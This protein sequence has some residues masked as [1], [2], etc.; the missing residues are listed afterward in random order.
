[1]A[2]APKKNFTPYGGWDQYK[3]FSPSMNPTGGSN[4]R[5]SDAAWLD[6]LRGKSSTPA[7]STTKRATTSYGSPNDFRTRKQEAEAERQVHAPLYAKSGGTWDDWLRN[8]GLGSLAKNSP[9]LGGFSGIGGIGPF[10]ASQAY[11]DA[12][13]YT[14]SLLQQLNSGRTAYSDKVDEMMNKIANRDKFSYDFNTD[15]LF[16]NALASAM[17]SG[18]NAMQDTIGQA[19]ALTGGYGSSYATSAANQA[20]NSFVQ[21]AYAQLPDYYNLALNAYNMEGQEMYNQLGMYQ[22]A[23]NTAYGR[24]ADAYSMNLANAQNMWN[25]EYSNYW[26]TANYNQAAAKFNADQK[27]KYDAL[28]WDKQQYADSQKRYE[29]EQAYKRY[30]DQV[31][32]AQWAAKQAGSNAANSGPNYAVTADAK[33][34]G[35]ILDA[36]K[37]S[38]EAG[39]YQYSLYLNQMTDDDADYIEQ[40][41]KDNQMGPYKPKG[42]WF[43]VKPTHVK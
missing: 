27:Y 29:S 17:K 41:L 43:G 20:Y 28:A 4:N 19:S 22:T 6:Y 15:P 39:D 40:W 35:A 9:G 8:N 37:E 3:T 10:H 32:D 31:S 2:D 23:D 12:M 25:Q 34:L 16:Q 24:L 1:M 11:Q 33:K 5:E 21:D 30:R 38:E 42:G 26:D 13:A 7:T 18:Q 14:N 36:Y